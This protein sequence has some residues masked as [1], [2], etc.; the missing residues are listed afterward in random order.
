M[1]LIKD[2]VISF[3]LDGLNKKRPAFCRSL[4]IH[5]L[6]ATTTA[7]TVSV[8]GFLFSAERTSATTGSD[9]IGIINLKSA[10]HQET[11][12]LRA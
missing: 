1:K 5:E 3:F 8:T 12:T 7:I 9:S 4:V 11:K 2:H 6:V 10:A